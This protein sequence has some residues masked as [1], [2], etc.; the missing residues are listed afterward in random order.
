[1]IDIKSGPLFPWQFRL[2]AVLAIIGAVA[3]FQDHYWVSAV[4]I[5]VGVIGLV[6]YEGTEVNAENKTFREYTSLLF[7]KTGKFSNYL[8]VEKI[9]ITRSKQSQQMYTA[10]TTHS[11]VFEDVVYNAFLKFESGEKVHLLTSKDKDKLV[12]VLEPLCKKLTMD[13]VD[14]A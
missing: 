5:L 6:S 8:E 11:S 9:Y 1:M 10:H 3:I 14:Y 12:K 7:I 4:L 2:V 13:V